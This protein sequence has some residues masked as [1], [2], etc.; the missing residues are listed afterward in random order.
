MPSSAPPCSST[1][2]ELSASAA[3][4]LRAALRPHDA[5]A[6][7]VVELDAF[8]RAATVVVG[9]AA[10]ARLASAHAVAGGRSPGC[11]PSRAHLV[12]YGALLASVAPASVAAPTS[13]AAADAPA[14]GAADGRCDGRR[15]AAGGFAPP[16]VAP[17]TPT[18]MPTPPP[19]PAPAAGCASQP[20]AAGGRRAAGAQSAYNP[21]LL[22]WSADDAAPS[23]AAAPPRPQPSWAFDAAPPPTPPPPPRSEGAVDELLFGSGL[24]PHSRRK[25][26]VCTVLVLYATC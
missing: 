13:L 2:P 4:A 21:S 18:P 20:R 16:R 9:V 8:L 7:G 22:A 17:P 23:P 11:D 3:V 25:T 24:D 26:P 15:R 19:V 1:A 12:D 5:R 6:D 14:A 10:C